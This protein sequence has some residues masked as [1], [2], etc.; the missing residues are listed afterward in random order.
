MTRAGPIGDLSPARTERSRAAVS[1]VHVGALALAVEDHD[2]LGGRLQGAEGVRGHRRE[3]GGL[4]SVD[5]DLPV[6]EPQAH[7]ALEHD[8]PVVTRVDPLLGPA[9]GRLEAHL[10]RD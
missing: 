1:L 9:G 6:P 7:L 2:E 5:V 3:L 10:Y 4:A 8:E